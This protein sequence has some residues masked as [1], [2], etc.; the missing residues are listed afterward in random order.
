MAD[1]NRARAIRDL[2]LL[3][4][5]AGLA[6]DVERLRAIEL[7]AAA[8]GLL[9]SLNGGYQNTLILARASGSDPAERNIKKY[10]DMHEKREKAGPAT[11]A[12]VIA[13]LKR[14]L[15]DTS[16][17]DKQRDGA[18]KALELFGELEPKAITSK[19]SIKPM[20][21]IDNE[22]V[23]NTMSAIELQKL[24]SSKVTRAEELTKLLSNPIW[25]PAQKLVFQKDRDALLEEVRGLQK[26]F[27]TAFANEE[28]EARR[29]EEALQDAAHRKNPPIV[30]TSSPGLS[31][32]QARAFAR[33]DNQGFGIGPV[34]VPVAFKRGAHEMGFMTPA[35]A[36]A[37]RERLRAAGIL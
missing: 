30:P 21:Y 10:L 36:Q 28:R 1:V 31:P 23:Q 19:E 26:K 17:T 34:E 8:S 20:A 3:I 35:Q 15:A 2:E 9:S 32:A 11:R 12:E 27:E 16:S 18:R 25:E 29:D 24:I 37:H 4:E 22:Y 14:V 7:Q 5:A 6:G 33:L 13:H